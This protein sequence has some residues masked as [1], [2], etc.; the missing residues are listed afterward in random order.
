MQRI[1]DAALAALKGQL[2]LVFRHFPLIRLHPHAQHAAE[3]AEAAGERGRFWPMHELLFQ[4]QDSLDDANLV[5]YAASLELDPEWVQICLRLHTYTGR[6]QR[7]FSGGVQSGVAGVPTCF[8]NEARYDGLL[9]VG[10]VVLALQGAAYEVRRVG[11][12]RGRPVLGQEGVL[13]S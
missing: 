6:V 3:V 8:I 5:R 12:A 4:R 1:V 10:P 7:D 13:S 11:F 2:R 9:E